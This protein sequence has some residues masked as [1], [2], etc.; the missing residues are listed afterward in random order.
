MY[1]LEGVFSGKLSLD[2]SE[3]ST[4]RIRRYGFCGMRSKK[5]HFSV[6]GR[7]WGT[8]LR[9]TNVV[10]NDGKIFMW[11]LLKSGCQLLTRYN[12]IV[13]WNATANTKHTLSRLKRVERLR[14]LDQ[15]VLFCEGQCLSEVISSVLGFSKWCLLRLPSNSTK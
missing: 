5:V 6:L 8:N 4:W 3:E 15:I 10:T 1:I 12:K 14:A 2:M 11:W 7:H 13:L 9:C